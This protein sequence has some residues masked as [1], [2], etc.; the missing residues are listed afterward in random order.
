MGAA[1]GRGDDVDEGA[2]HRLV[3]G[4][5]AQRDRDVTSAL[6]V[7]G[8][9]VAFAVQNRDVLGEV[10]LPLQPDDPGDWLIVGQVVHVLRDP[11]FEAERLLKLVVLT[12]DIVHVNGQ[13]RHEEGGLASAV[14]Q[15]VAVEGGVFGED[16]R[17]RPEPDAGA[18][19]G[20]GYCAALVQA[21]LPGE[22]RVR[23]LP[24]ED[25]RNAA[26][27]RHSPGAA[28]PVDLNVQPRAK[29][30]DH[31]GSHTMQTTRRA[32]R[33]AAELAAR[34]QLGHHQLDAGQPGLLLD[35][36][37]DTAAVVLHLDAAIG[38][39]GHRDIGAES[40]QRLVHGVVD[41]LPDA[42]HQSAGVG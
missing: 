41:D 19:P 37:R 11:A 28:F 35:V 38:Q 42:V 6:D 21:R 17:V 4:P 8:A 18:R 34:M 26:P 16:L 39:Q 27:E 7:L 23:T 29:R 12:A 3:T 32:V 24:L 20:P 36:D 10:A 2:G 1:L 14:P 33:T 31:R 9:E 22:R 40:G 25:P 30:V 15:R 5:P 13:V